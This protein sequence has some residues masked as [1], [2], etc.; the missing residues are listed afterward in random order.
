MAY[1]EKRP[2]RIIL[3]RHAESEGN[4]DQTKYCSIADSRIQ[5]TSNGVKQAEECGREIRQLI[6]KTGNEGWKVYFYVSPYTRT[7]G[8]L[9]GIG[10]AFERNRILGVREEPRVREQ[11]FGNF[12]KA[13]R[14]RAIKETRDQFGRFF[15]R[16]PEGESG[17][18]VF[19]R[20]TSFLESLWRD[21]DMNRFNCEQSTDL[22]LIIVTHGVAMRIFFMRWFKWT[23]EQFELL[24]N[25]QNCEFRVMELGKGG[26][27]SLAVNHSRKDLE[28]WG[29][30]EEMIVDQEWR[31]V[32][33]KGHWNDKWQGTG[34]AFFDHFEE[35]NKSTLDCNN[36]HCLK[37]KTEVADPLCARMNVNDDDD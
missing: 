9:K 5:L 20:V 11:D 26:D 8:T 4:I 21:I 22:N 30:S 33:K 28:K 29:L 2:V 32:A 10:R 27:Y 1:E 25:A 12:Q 15:Y 35:E 13:E 17:A 19:D 36:T 16:F 31:A 14:M 3:V 18:D 24:N 23:T 34:R 37:S 6:E 7:L